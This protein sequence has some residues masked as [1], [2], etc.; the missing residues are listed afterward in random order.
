VT[1]AVLCIF[2]IGLCVGSF[3]NVLADRLPHGESV[4]WG[5]SHCDYC[6]S[7]LRWFEL[8]PV[9]SFILQ[10]GRCIRC[11]KTLSIQYPLV[12][13]VT[14]IGFLYIYQV[15]SYSI[16]LLFAYL[17]IYSCL[18]VIFIADYKSQIIPDSM[19]VGS[20]LGT[21]LLIL[22]GVI[23]SGEL[24]NHI[25]SG[26]GA[27]AFFYF[28]WRAT[29][30]RGMGFGDV[31]FSFFMGLFLGYPLIII[32]DYMAFLTGAIVGVILIMRGRKK[33][34]STIAFGPF[35]VLGVVGAFVWGTR[36]LEWWERLL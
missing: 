36:I 29:R 25:L 22:G 2:F 11:H 35:L 14:A 10:R 3:L 19:I 8:V 18:L 32:A 9:L 31:K 17:L 20:L 26:I 24:H 15:F 23:P 5:R 6:A 7:T 12:E 4:L 1:C 16:I 13:F 30:G 27:C 21:V 34:K 28:L 33:L